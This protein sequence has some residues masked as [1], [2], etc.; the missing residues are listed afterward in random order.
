M[1]NKT[2]GKRDVAAL[3]VATSPG[4]EVFER[5]HRRLVETVTSDGILDV[6]YTIIDTP[7]GS[8]LL[9]ATEKGLARVAYASE[10]HDKVLGDIANTLS[11]RILRA[12]QRLDRVAREIDEYFIGTRKTFDLQLDM[13]LS[14]GFRQRVQCHLPDIAYGHTESYAE[15]AAFVGNPKAVRA[16]GSACATNPIPIVIPCHRVLR[17]DGTLGGYV[18]GLAVKSALLKLESAS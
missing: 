1:T 5:L 9:A 7:V 18:G 15:V 2:I 4:Q 13:S 3:L 6:A 10:D 12:P 11:S 17:S 16:V 14:S 8:L